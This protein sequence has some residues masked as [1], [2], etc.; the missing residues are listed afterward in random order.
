MIIA[1]QTG[2]STFVVCVFVLLVSCCFGGRECACLYC[3]CFGLKHQR[4]VTSLQGTQPWFTLTVRSVLHSTVLFVTDQHISS[5]DDRLHCG[6]S[7]SRRHTPKSQSIIMQLARTS[8]HCG[9]IVTHT[10][11]PEHYCEACQDIEALWIYSDSHQKARALLC[12]LPGH[13]STV[14]I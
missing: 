6:Y 9:Y 3:C 5:V 14:D 2:T 13:R 4:S 1:N 10:K 7:D 8:K 11:K 12:S